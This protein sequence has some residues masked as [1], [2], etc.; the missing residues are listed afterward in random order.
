[1]VKF[2]D[3]HLLK[4]TKSSKALQIF[5]VSTTYRMLKRHST[6][7]VPEAESSKLEAERFQRKVKYE[8]HLKKDSEHYPYVCIFKYQF[9]V[10]DLMNQNN[11]KQIAE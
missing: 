3:D 1:M 4:D 5:K 10:Y 9:F 6:P 2:M 8:Y 7:T 11:V